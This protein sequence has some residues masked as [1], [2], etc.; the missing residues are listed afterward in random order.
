MVRFHE[1]L[2]ESSVHLRYFRAMKLSQRVAHE[3]LVRICFLDYDRELALVADRLDPGSGAHEVLAVGR[4]SK[5][6]GGE[7]AE[8]AL[9]VRDGAQGHGL[10]SELVRRLMAVAR[11]ERLRRI[12]ADILPENRAMQHIC[13]KFGFKLEQLLDEPLVRAQLDL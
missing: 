11:D 4:L 6:P 12:V 10:G 5:L 7:Q 3:R 8:F 1:K 2:S 13:R 9:L